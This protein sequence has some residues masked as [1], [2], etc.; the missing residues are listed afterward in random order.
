MRGKISNILTTASERELT[1]IY[2]YIVALLR[3]G[4]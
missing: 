3:L 4:P 2:I 1:L